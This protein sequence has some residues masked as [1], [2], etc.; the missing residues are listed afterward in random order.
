MPE[1]PSLRECLNAL[2][3]FGLP[4]VDHIVQTY[5]TYYN[6]MRPH[7]S[8]GNVPLGESDGPPAEE[9]AGSIEG[10]RRWPASSQQFQRHNPCADRSR[11]VRFSSLGVAVSDAEQ[12]DHG[13]PIFRP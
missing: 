5:V 4:Q 12:L 9:V 8:L 11:E 10:V 3:C 13:D 6:T 7:Q 1:S 2:A